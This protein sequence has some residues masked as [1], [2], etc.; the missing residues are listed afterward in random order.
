M[1]DLN[2]KDELPIRKFSLVTSFS[3]LLFEAEASIL[4]SFRVIPL[5]I[6]TKGMD[7]VCL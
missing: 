2:L 6:V 4:F 7:D 5:V 3:G 1:W